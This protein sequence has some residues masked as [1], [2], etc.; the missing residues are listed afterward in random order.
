MRA[1]P[2]ALVTAPADAIVRYAGPFLEYG[3]VVVLEPDPTTMIVLAGLAQLRVET[4][5]PVRRGELLGA[6]RRKAARR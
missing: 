4:G 3:Y 5:A 2:F 6:P 1:T